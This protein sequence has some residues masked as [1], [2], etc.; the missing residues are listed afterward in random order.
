MEVRTFTRRRNLNKY[1]PCGKS[2]KDGKF[3]PFKGS[4]GEPYGYCHSCLKTFS[5]D[6][7]DSVV[8]GNIKPLKPIIYCDVSDDIIEEKFDINKE[9]TF[10]QFLEEIFG[11]TATKI[12]IENYYLG[13]MDNNVIF[14]QIDKSNNVRCGKIMSYNPNG[15]RGKYIN[16]WHSYNKQSCKIKQCFFGEHLIEFD[17]PVW[18]VESEKTAIIMSLL[19]P[20]R[21]WIACG[22]LGGLSPDKCE[23]I[24]GHYQ[25]ILCPDAGCYDEWAKEGERYGFDLTYDS[26]NYY[27]KGLI[28]EG[29]DIADYYLKNFKEEIKSDFFP[30]KIDPTWD[31][32]VDKN[33]S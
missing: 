30:K 12:A 21:V 11:E 18:I 10:T 16:W 32:F 14:W 5:K 26:E 28:D 13:H 6:N 20:D 9:S 22:S 8:I 19:K 7:R 23:S 27:K 17:K 15:K 1:C 25:V 29:E 33:Q 31:Y 3:A 2:N 24:L 4:E